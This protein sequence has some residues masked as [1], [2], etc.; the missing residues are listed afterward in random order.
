MKEPFYS[1]LADIPGVD[2]NHASGSKFVFLDSSQTP[3]KLMQFA[4][5]KLPSGGRVEPH[6]HPTMEEYFYFQ[7]GNGRC[8][9]GDNV[10]IIAPQMFLRIPANVVHSFVAE[11]EDELQ[12]VYFGVA[13]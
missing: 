3:G 1:F 8:M 5:G 9:L 7:S 6:K 11:G 13:L 12:F 10:I 2:V 4:F